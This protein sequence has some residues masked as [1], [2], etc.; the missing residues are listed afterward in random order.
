MEEINAKTIKYARDYV[1]DCNP[2]SISTLL[3][4]IVSD[5]SDYL[6]DVLVIETQCRL[7]LTELLTNAL[8]HSLSAKTIIRISIDSE[9]LQITKSDEGRP[10]YLEKW[11]ER[12]ELE[13]PL[14]GYEG[15]KLVI[16][17]D[18]MCCLYGYIDSPL[19]VSFSTKDFPIQTPPRPKEILEHFGLMILTKASDRFTYTYDPEEKA[20]IFQSQILFGE[21]GG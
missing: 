19:K 1:F 20:N 18:L 6:P 17:E 9:K 13:W 16:Y 12:E 5:I 10:F 14:Y 3:N 2:S 4:T 21:K 11:K 8:K 7:I 15:K